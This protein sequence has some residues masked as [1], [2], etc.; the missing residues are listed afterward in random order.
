MS[1]GPQTTKDR[2]VEAALETI[3]AE[4]FAGTSAREIA[5]RGGFNQALIFYHFGTVNDLLLVALDRASAQTLSRYRDALASAATLP[6]RLRGVI[7]L[8]RE[9]LICGHVTVVS[10]MIGGS[11]GH[12][13]LGPPVVARMEPWVG[14]VEEAVGDAIRELGL[15]EIIP[16]RTAAMA[17]VALSLGVDLVYH[18][19][20]DPARVEALFELAERVTDLI[21]PM[22]A[23]VREGGTDVAERKRSDSR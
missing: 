18:L 14:L 4:G 21:V 7:E 22:L 11:L 12:P 15:T 2:I 1:E 5:R 19:E 3:K 13:G 23:D 17:V 10:E 8:Y 6:E 9:D 16:P 20:R